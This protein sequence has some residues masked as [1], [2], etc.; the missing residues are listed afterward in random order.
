IIPHILDGSTAVKWNVRGHRPCPSARRPKLRLTVELLEDR[1]APSTTSWVQGP[2][3]VVVV[4]DENHSFSNIIGSSSAPY[5]NSLASQGAL[6]T[7]YVAIEHP[8]QPNYLDIYSGSNQGVTNDGSGAVCT[9]SSV[10]L[11]QELLGAGLTWGAYIEGY[12]NGSYDD[13]HVTCSL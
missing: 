2:D 9:F 7:N 3:H 5:I 11:G 13:S 12:A 8:S 4:I 1:L 10:N 6:M